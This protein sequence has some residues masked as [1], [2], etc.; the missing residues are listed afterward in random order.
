[1][2]Y[3]D[4]NMEGAGVM[5]SILRRIVM[6]LTS[7]QVPTV[8]QSI[9][10]SG[11]SESKSYEGLQ[12]LSALKWALRGKQLFVKSDIINESFLFPCDTRATKLASRS[13]AYRATIVWELFNSKNMKTPTE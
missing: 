2:N 6:P 9:N 3:S 7:N 1:M 11:N 10:S 4:N 13:R 5:M 8:K 12:G